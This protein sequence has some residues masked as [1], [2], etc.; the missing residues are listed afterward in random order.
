MVTLFETFN[1]MVWF[2]YFPLS[3]LIF[4]FG[5]WP[6]MKRLAVNWI[7]AFWVIPRHSIVAISLAKCFVF[8]TNSWNRSSSMC[9]Y[10]QCWTNN[11]VSR[12]AFKVFR[13]FSSSLIY[14]DLNVAINVSKLIKKWSWEHETINQKLYTI[15]FVISPAVRHPAESKFR[16][17]YLLYR[18][19]QERLTQVKQLVGF[20]SFV[21]I[22]NMNENECFNKVFIML[23][24]A[25]QAACS[26][27]ERKI[28]ITRTY[29]CSHATFDLT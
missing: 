27:F 28:M 26:K 5:A 8:L 3:G 19:L 17:I 14:L 25:C 10:G 15:E 29:P 6:D 20:K 2:C 11:F 16:G 24:F 22:F 18:P 21:L 1:L 23:L 13:I 7:Q 12:P 9:Y 4:M